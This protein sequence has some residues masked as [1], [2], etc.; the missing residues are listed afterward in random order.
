MGRMSQVLALT[1]AACAVASAFMLARTSVAQG[2]PPSAPATD[3]EIDA[4]IAASLAVVLS[5]PAHPTDP[6]EIQACVRVV[7]S[8]LYPRL[9]E[10]ELR[11]DPAFVQAQSEAYATFLHPETVQAAIESDPVAVQQRAEALKALGLGAAEGHAAYFQ[12]LSATLP[13]AEQA[14][15]AD[16]QLWN[17]PEWRRQREEPVRA[18]APKSSTSEQ[19]AP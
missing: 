9:E 10:Q 4:A 16:A 15:E 1:L 14:R 13:T 11:K 17:N 3:S 12:A 2:A 6:D 18:L 19:P 7:F 5:D 8:V